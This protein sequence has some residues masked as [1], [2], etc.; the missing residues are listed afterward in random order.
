MHTQTPHKITILHVEDDSNDV[1]L[2][3]RAFELEQVSNPLQTVGDGEQAIAYL[4]G[5][6]RFADRT[7]HPLPGLLLLDMKMPKASGLEVL[8]WVRTR[9]ELNALPVAFLTA[10]F[11]TADVALAY[12][13]GASAF[14][15]KP[16]NFDELR[17]IVRFLGGWV[18]Q[19][20]PPP[21]GEKDWIAL[22]FQD[23]EDRWPQLF[24]RA[25]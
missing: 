6:G 7:R 16:R 11:T 24:R 5:E 20:I 10:S 4:V 2:L 18:Q 9:R 22:T 23:L 15:V 21:T 3:Q 14:I 25:A 1:Y 17:G 12:H 8:K 13:L 19:T